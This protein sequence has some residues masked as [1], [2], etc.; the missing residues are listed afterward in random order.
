MV[1]GEKFFLI[2]GALSRP[3]KSPDHHPIEHEWNIAG[4]QRPRHPQPK[5][6]N[7]ILSD[8]EQQACNSIPQ[9]DIHY[10]LCMEESWPGSATR[11]KCVESI[12]IAT[13]VQDLFV[14]R[15]IYNWNSSGFGLLLTLEAPGGPQVRQPLNPPLRT[16]PNFLVTNSSRIR[17][18]FSL[19]YKRFNSVR[20]NGFKWKYFLDVVINKNKIYN[21]MRYRIGNVTADNF[22]RRRLWQFV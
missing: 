1:W 19:T 7:L 11:L 13:S 12:G 3:A 4:Q 5:L 6:S 22:N 8:K 9:T 15:F 21:P 16:T 2:A 20:N 18:G 17:R 10:I 14:A